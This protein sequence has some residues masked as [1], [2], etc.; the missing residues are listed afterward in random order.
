MCGRVV[1]LRRFMIEM[2]VVRRTALIAATIDRDDIIIFVG[3][4]AKWR[5]IE[6]KY[7]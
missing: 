4:L 5:Y 6:A 7:N 2:R 3:N 1:N